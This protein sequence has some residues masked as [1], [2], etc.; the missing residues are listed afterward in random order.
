MNFGLKYHAKYFITCKQGLHGVL[1]TYL[2]DEEAQLPVTDHRHLMVRLYHVLF[3]DAERRS[4]G[5]CKARV[6][7]EFYLKIQFKRLE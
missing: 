7:Q 5:L 3:N 2:S 6:N 1:H 4:Q